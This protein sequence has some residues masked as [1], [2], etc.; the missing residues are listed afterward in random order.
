MSEKYEIKLSLPEA[1]LLA[2]Y[3]NDLQKASGSALDLLF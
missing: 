3:V 2:L 1:L